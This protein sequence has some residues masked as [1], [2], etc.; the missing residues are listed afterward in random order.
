VAKSLMDSAETA[1]LTAHASTEAARTQVDLSTAA[2]KQ[3]ETNLVYTKILSPVDGIVISRNVDVG[4]TVAASFQTPTLFVIAADLTQMQIDT[5]VDE[6][7]IS[8]VKVGQD[9]EFNV[10]AYPDATFKGKVFQVRNAAVTVQNVV[11][12]D[13]VVSVDNKDMRLMPGMT[14]D[15]SIITSVVRNVLRVPNAALRFKP[16]TTASRPAT[17]AARPVAGGQGGA[18]RPGAGASAV[19][20]RTAAGATPGGGARGPS[21]YCLENGKLRR[22]P[23]KIGMSDGTYTELLSGDL[24]EGQEVVVESLVKRAAQTT[25]F[26]MF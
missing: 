7:D 14:V 20:G 5:T 15:V 10:D 4:Q 21:V 12:Y 1:Y 24:K 3:A 17:A 13:V 18:G 16:A 6:A 9:V 22:L 8:S 25:G 26:R 23:V 11:T 19:S 2:L